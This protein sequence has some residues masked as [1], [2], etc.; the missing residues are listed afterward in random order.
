MKDTLLEIIPDNKIPNLTKKVT[1]VGKFNFYGVHSDDLT[2]EVAVLDSKHIGLIFPVGKTITPLL[3]RVAELDPMDRARCEEHIRRCVDEGYIG[4]FAKLL[5]HDF[6][7]EI[8]DNWR[9]AYGY[10]WMKQD[11][12]YVRLV[13]LLP[14]HD[15]DLEVAHRIATRLEVYAR[16]KGYDIFDAAPA[17]GA[18]AYHRRKMN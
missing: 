1:A 15:D 7:E 12:R 3:K 11:N 13:L 14:E 9:Q 6:N 4:A 18:N 2:A 8:I 16:N 10:R 17:Y 5:E